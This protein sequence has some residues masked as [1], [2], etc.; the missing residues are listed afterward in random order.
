MKDSMDT[1][2]KTITETM[3]ARLKTFTDTMNTHSKIITG[4]LIIF[5]VLAVSLL[6]QRPAPE[7][8]YNNHPN[9]EN[10]QGSTLTSMF[11]NLETGK[12][13]KLH[14]AI[15]GKTSIAYVDA[16]DKGYLISE[17]SVT[18]QLKSELMGAVTKCLV[19]HIMATNKFQVSYQ[20]TSQGRHQLHIKVKGEHIKGSPF[21][22]TACNEENGYFNQGG[23]E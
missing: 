7:K 9:S 3:D 6:Y 12:D 21:T 15:E 14:E 8:S 4:I 18:C 10:A 13:S 17:A 19:K 1:H 20:A 5:C 11:Q 2:L 16:G 23:Q 22:V